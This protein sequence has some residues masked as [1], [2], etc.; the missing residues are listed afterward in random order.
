MGK[1]RRARHPL[2]LQLRCSA[3]RR[4]RAQTTPQQLGAVSSVTLAL[5]EYKFDQESV[6]HL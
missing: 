6:L 5:L 1:V 2:K 3:G 4:G